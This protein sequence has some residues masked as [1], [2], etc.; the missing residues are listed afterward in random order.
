VLKVRHGLIE[1]IG[2]AWTRLTR[3]R[4][5]GRRLLRSFS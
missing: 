2:I 3:T 4:A 5:Q 1:E